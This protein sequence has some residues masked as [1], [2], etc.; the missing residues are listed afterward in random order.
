MAD[1]SFLTAFAESGRE[2]REDAVSTVLEPLFD[3]IPRAPPLH[4]GFLKLFMGFAPFTG[5]AGS[6]R[7]RAAPFQTGPLMGPLRVPD[8]AGLAPIKRIFSRFWHG[9][10]ANSVEERT[11]SS[12]VSAPGAPPLNICTA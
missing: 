10:F 4:V 6:K 7:D 9:K 11:S 2:A 1:I 8:R 12:F 5:P 3:V